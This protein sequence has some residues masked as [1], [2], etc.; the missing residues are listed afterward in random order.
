MIVFLRCYIIDNSTI[1]I[2]RCTLGYIQGGHWN[3]ENPSIIFPN[4]IIKKIEETCDYKSCFCWISFSSHTL[5]LN[6]SLDD[7][8]KHFNF[9]LNSDELIALTTYKQF[10]PIVDDKQRAEKTRYVR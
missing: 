7:V 3:T 9:D 10:H 6:L 8:S 4:K 2:P 1:T 5:Y